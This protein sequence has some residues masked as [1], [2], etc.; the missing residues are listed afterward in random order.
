MVER[1]ELGRA[2]RVDLLV[3][4]A[5]CDDRSPLVAGH[6]A[7]ALEDLVTVATG[8]HQVEDH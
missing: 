6:R 5:D 1:T 2:D 3:G 8:H 4:V 7:H